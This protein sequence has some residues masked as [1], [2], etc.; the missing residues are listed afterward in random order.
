MPVIL[1]GHRG[2][3]HLLIQLVRG[4]QD[5]LEDRRRLLGAGDFH[6]NPEGQGVV[7]HRLADVENVH[8]TLG[9]NTGNGGGQTW[10]VFP[11]D[12]NQDNFAQSAPPGWK[13]PHSTHFQ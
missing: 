9:Q 6:Q 5:V 11:R 3:T 1:F 4:K 2:E 10:P 8:T 7:D 13:K 12:V